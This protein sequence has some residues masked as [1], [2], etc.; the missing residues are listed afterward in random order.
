MMCNGSAEARPWQ[1]VRMVS[2]VLATI[3]N[4]L[5]KVM[6]YY[7]LST[8]TYYL[9]VLFQFSMCWI[10][11]IIALELAVFS[12]ALFIFFS[13]S[14]KAGFDPWRYH[15]WL[16]ILL[17][18]LICQPGV[19]V[20][21]KGPFLILIFKHSFGRKGVIMVFAFGREAIVVELVYL[22]ERSTFINVVLLAR[23]S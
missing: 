13:H 1:E 8:A 12:R 23:K 15:A 9:S 17:A 19:T 5:H 14:H 6:N 4:V 18:H 22:G 10:T 20:L 7:V 2:Q 21:P 16:R 11:D 3:S